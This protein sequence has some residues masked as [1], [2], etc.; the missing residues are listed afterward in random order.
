MTIQTP[1]N[2]LWLGSVFDETTMLSSPAV[3]PAANRWQCGLLNSLAKIGCRIRLLGHLPEPAWP[4]GRLCFPPLDENIA[5]MG[6]QSIPQ[7]CVAYWNFPRLREKLLA[8]RYVQA[9]RRLILEEGRPDVVASYNTDSF[10]VAVAHEA[11]NMGIPWVP[12]V[13]DAPGDAAFSARL[14]KHLGLAAGA[15]FLSQSLFTTAAVHSKLHLDG[16]VNDLRFNPNDPASYM[17]SAL[18]IIFYSGS[19]V[20]EFGI[21]TLIE[22]FSKLPDPAVRLV[23]C[24]KGTFKAL[25]EAVW[26]D[27]RIE[28]MGCLSDEE[29]TGLARM[30]SVM[31][32]PRSN[33]PD[34]K[35]NF[36]SKVLEYLSYGKPVVS[37]WTPGLEPAYQSLLI[38]SEYTPLALANS[39]RKGLAW[40]SKRRSEHARH[41]AAFLKKHKLWDIQA[42]RLVEW[43]PLC[44]P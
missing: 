21:A 32:N 24:G 28:L 34:H 42:Q 35:N 44:R 14:A 4:R 12:M 20:K 1:L 23:I 11:R 33:L 41:C 43:L 3:S 30:S 37:T 17:P 29:L 19:V 6:Q 5:L 2:I 13:A 25:D 39:I 9:F 26:R 22:A 15:V 38:V 18:P 27:P 8:R 31:V 7:R 10:S 16:G 36:P 40:S